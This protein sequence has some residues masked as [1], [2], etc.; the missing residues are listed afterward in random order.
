MSHAGV[1]IDQEVIGRQGD[2]ES[3]QPSFE[4]PLHGGTEFTLLE[5]QGCMVADRAAGR[6]QFLDTGKER[7]VGEGKII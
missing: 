7:G 3:Y 1:I 6:P 2:A 5:E 4:D